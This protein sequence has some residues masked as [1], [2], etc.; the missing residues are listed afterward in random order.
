MISTNVFNQLF[1][2]ITLLRSIYLGYFFFFSKCKSSIKNSNEVY[3]GIRINVMHMNQIQPRDLH[4][5]YAEC[6]CMLTNPLPTPNALKTVL[7]NNLQALGIKFV[8]TTFFAA[9]KE[10]KF[11]CYFNSLPDHKILDWS[12]MKQIADNI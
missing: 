3:L 2:K 5:R 8:F 1:V 6:H 4:L 9:K 7:Q 10:S 12:K 11:S